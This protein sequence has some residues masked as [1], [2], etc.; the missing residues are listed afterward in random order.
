MTAVDDLTPQ[1]RLALFVQQNR[2]MAGEFMPDGR[3]AFLV[4][5][6][7]GVEICIG[8]EPTQVA[9]LTDLYSY[10]HVSHAVF[11]WQDWGDAEFAGEPDGWIRH[12]PSNRRRPDGDASR[13]E[14][15]P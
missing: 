15:R 13:E 9:G 12:R 11:A 1:A 14:I 2:Y 10:A 4:P 7:F 5:R 6:I 3:V 8:A